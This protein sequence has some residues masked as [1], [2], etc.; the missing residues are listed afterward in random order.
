MN[1]TSASTLYPIVSMRHLKSMRVAIH[2]SCF[3]SSSHLKQDRVAAQED[4]PGQVAEVHGDA[5]RDDK[6]AARLAVVLLRER[7]GPDLNPEVLELDE[8]ATGRLCWS[9]LQNL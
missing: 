1:S 8:V 4:S 5:G 2:R 3:C 9:M 6:A 7:Q